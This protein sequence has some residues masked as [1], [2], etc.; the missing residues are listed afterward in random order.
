M[1]VDD[2]DDGDDAFSDLGSDVEKEMAALADV[3]DTGR[4]VRRRLNPAEEEPQTPV[5]TRTVHGLPTPS[6]ARTLFPS[7]PQRPQKS[8]SFEEDTP[9]KTPTATPAEDGTTPATPATPEASHDPTAEVMA[10]LS[11]HGLDASV[12]AS[13]RGVLAR[14]AQRAH[15]VALGRDFVRSASRDKDARI[16][17][18]QERVAALET[19]EWSFRVREREMNDQI[20][21]MKAGLA[22]MY[23]EN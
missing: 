21:K 8:V 12:L 20:T 23:Q 13:V 15:G 18:L 1:V 17:K 7:E 4:N 19:K 5:T 22:R 3:A 2:D 16:A 10:L 11:G 6:T 14:H 9:S